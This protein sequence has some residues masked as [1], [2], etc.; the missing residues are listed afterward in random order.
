ML[1]DLSPGSGYSDEAS[2]ECLTSGGSCGGDLD[3]AV[4]RGE[5]MV[6]RT[7]ADDQLLGNLCIG[8][9]HGNETQDLNFAPGQSIW[10]AW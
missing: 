7:R 1:A 5:V 2:L 9:A 4:D 10:M 6:D 3:L 8:P